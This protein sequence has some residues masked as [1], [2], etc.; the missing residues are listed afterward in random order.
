MALYRLNAGTG[1]HTLEYRPWVICIAGRTATVSP[2]P[3][4]VACASSVAVYSYL[5]DD[6]G[7]TMVILS[8]FFIVFI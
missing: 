7:G 2:L 5:T 4:V 3:A 6:D 1:P 8:P